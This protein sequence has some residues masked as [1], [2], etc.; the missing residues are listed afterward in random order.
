MGLKR[1]DRSISRLNT[2][3]ANQGVEVPLR[4]V[5]QSFGS[6]RSL[7]TGNLFGQEALDTTPIGTRHPEAWPGHGNVTAPF[8]PRPKALEQG[9]KK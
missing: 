4:C 3:L 1:R 7:T 6:K 8:L 2:R 5:T 9:A